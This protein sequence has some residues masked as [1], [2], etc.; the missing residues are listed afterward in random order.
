M[1]PSATT[2]ATE[3]TN[4]FPV[5]VERL[6]VTNA[7]VSFR[8]EALPQPFE[9]RLAPILITVG[10]LST[11]T[12][13]TA[14]VSFSARTDGDEEAKFTGA[15][16]V[17]PLVCEGTFAI[18][19]I[20]LAR[21]RPYAEA[22][23]PVV[24]T[25]GVADF[26]IPFRVELDGTNLNARVR[27]A[28]FAV[29]DLAVIEKTNQAPL[30]EMSSIALEGLEVA[31]QDK[32]ASLERVELDTGA[33]HVRR[34]A[35]TAPAE[36][37]PAQEGGAGGMIEPEAIERRIQELTD[38]QAKLGTIEM[39]G[40]T[41]NVL[42]ETTSPAARLALTE[43]ALSAQDIS[44]AAGGP[45]AR[46]ELSALWGGAGKITVSASVNN[47]PVGADLEIGLDGIA[48]E[49][50]DPYIAQFARLTLNRG[51]LS[52]AIKAGYGRQS[53][54]AGL[55]RA[56]GNLALKDFVATEAAVGSDFISWDAVELNDFNVAL[57]PNRLSL[58]ELIVRQLQTSLIVHADGQLNVLRILQRADELTE[59]A[60]R[61]DKPEVAQTARE[62]APAEQEPK[63][64]TADA[65]PPDSP[66][67]GPVTAW[68]IRV[69]AVRL[70]GV[71]L[72]AAD[73]FYADGFRTTVE[74]IDGEIRDVTY[75]PEGPAEIDLTGRLTALP[76]SQSR[77][78]SSRIREI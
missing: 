74:S 11:R 6:V 60:A 71:S 73:Q 3:S 52:G 16:Q 37:Q 36:S 25:S 4:L 68:P 13:R 49:S 50:L 31:L 1:G 8:D 34:P 30:L 21:Y 56:S 29:G 19:D 44:N 75:P 55:V 42:D 10:D 17:Q 28:R 69:G 2:N 54:A 46:L 63:E 65:S 47:S 27:G 32:R 66:P 48:L 77:G 70:E 61:E 18:S 62:K 58:A 53:D 51:L 23:A 24:P 5:T 59:A 22:M 9:A 14:A 67:A 20:P 26:E 72:L 15:L 7:L 45:P 33:L 40:L 35:P 41:V 64:E 39:K 76:A 38:W 43:I 12:G 57:E 78:G